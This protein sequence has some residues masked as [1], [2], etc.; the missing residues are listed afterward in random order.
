MTP[1][2]PVT[3]AGPAGGSHHHIHVTTAQIYIRRNP[4]VHFSLRPG[5]FG[6]AQLHL[7][8]I[9]YE[10]R[11]PPAPD[12]TTANQEVRGDRCTPKPPSGTGLIRATADGS[13]RDHLTS[14]V[15]QQHRVAETW[16]LN[17]IVEY[18]VTTKA[19]QS[20]HFGRKPRLWITHISFRPENHSFDRGRLRSTLTCI[21]I[22]NHVTAN[23]LTIATSDPGG[24][25]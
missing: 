7:A 12:T 19:N 23:L 16:F 13:A 6:V 22:G 2:S 10:R 14:A 24:Q 25:D 9:I 3:R 5:V 15:L 18:H 21:R 11:R 4:R 8:R 1:R 17:Y 20:E